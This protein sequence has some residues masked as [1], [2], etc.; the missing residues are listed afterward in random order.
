M[1]YR[2]RDEW[3]IKSHVTHRDV[4]Q[5]VK[6]RLAAAVFVLAGLGLLFVVLEH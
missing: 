4:T 2:E 6:I 1:R 3:I 5:R